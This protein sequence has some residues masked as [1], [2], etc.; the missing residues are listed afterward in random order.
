M[1][2]IYSAFDVGSRN[3]FQISSEDEAYYFDIFNVDDKKKKYGVSIIVN[4]DV[5]NN[6]V[7]YLN[8]KEEAF[9]LERSCHSELFKFLFI[10]DETL[11]VDCF[12]DYD[13]KK[14]SANFVELNKHQIELLCK[15]LS[16]EII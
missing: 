8:K 13:Y 16:E 3:V 2:V 15:T 11:F 12:R 10:D 1:K 9:Y 7:D 6:L 4:F 14:T 5:L